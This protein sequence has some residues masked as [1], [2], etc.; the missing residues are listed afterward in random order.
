MRESADSVMGDTMPS[1]LMLICGGAEGLRRE[2]IETF[3]GTG[4]PPWDAGNGE[5]YEFAVAREGRL[6]GWDEA[7]ERWPI[8][9]LFT[10]LAGSAEAILL[11]MFGTDA[12]DVV[13]SVGDGASPFEDGGAD[14]FPRRWWMVPIAGD[15][16]ISV[17]L[18][19]GVTS[20]RTERLEP[21]LGRGVMKLPGLPGGAGDAGSEAPRCLGVCVSREGV[22]RGGRGGD[23]P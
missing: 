15:V 18:L 16:L 21:P 4:E 23:A 20:D 17:G 13:E 9:K 10:V 6:P 11:P 19:V 7:R 5:G 2:G 1:V 12:A 14:D 22:G 3:R 8:P